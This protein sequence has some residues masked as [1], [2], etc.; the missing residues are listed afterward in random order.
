MNPVLV[1]VYRGNVLESFHRGVV[2]VVDKNDN[3]V[4]SQGDVNQ[5][6]YP[7]SAMKL[8]Q[9][10]PLIMLGGI[11][12]FNFTLAE[13]AIMCGS[14]NAEP[15]HIETVNSILQKIGLTANELNCG[16]QYPSSKKQAN[17]LIRQNQK[18]Q[19]I[20]NNCSGKHAGMLAMCVLMNWSIHD[21]INSTHPLQQAI[22]EVCA[23]M[24]QYP[25]KHMQIALD[26]CSA[27]IFSV[28]VINQAIGY[29]NLI[30]NKHLPTDVQQA[31][32]IVIEA[33]SKY[34]FMV[35]GNGRY[36]T[37]M[38]NI[39]APHIIGKTGAEGIFCMA[40]AKQQLGV[41]IKIDDGKMHPQYMVAQ[42]II[43]ASK[44]FNQEVLM[45][46]QKYIADD[47]MNFNKLLTGKTS[48]NP[49]F[50]QQLQHLNLPN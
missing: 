3:V 49:Q 6:C 18:P 22:L 46:L 36:C 5:L 7:R 42:A 40:F 15:E 24:Y 4:F 50:M 1:D 48:V 23:T 12:K 44:Q 29:K 37:E 39:T 38:M 14:H 35:A 41:C 28:P 27:P 13:I 16:A 43:N 47:V 8:F 26:G 30:Y 9:V 19:H 2:C 20:H 10:L 31:C 34:P 11:S 45:P 21:Y 32:E 17:E 33:V 25:K